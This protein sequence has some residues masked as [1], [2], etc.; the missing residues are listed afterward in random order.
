A[1]SSTRTSQPAVDTFNKGQ[2]FDNE[3]ELSQIKPAE[4][5]IVS[6]AGG[7][8][9][10][11]YFGSV[12]VR[13]EPGVVIGTGYSKQSGRIGVGWDFGKR[14]K[15]AM[16]GNLLHSSSDRG[17]FNNDNTGTSMYVAL[18]SPPSFF[19]RRKRADR[20]YT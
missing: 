15:V 13:D 12:L 18:S 3:G 2:T 11:N 8:E 5:T 14:L 16:T 4:E 7:D 10:G 1:R 19:D 20:F 6:A 17:L 9:K